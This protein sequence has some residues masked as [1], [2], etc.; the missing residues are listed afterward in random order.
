MRKTNAQKLKELVRA[1]GENAKARV[2]IEA[3]VGLSTLE[4]MM[5]GTY[6]RVPRAATRERLSQYFGITE[7]ELF[8]LDQPKGKKAS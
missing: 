5:A 4:K 8:P 6:G 3:K 1:K 7:D 2:S